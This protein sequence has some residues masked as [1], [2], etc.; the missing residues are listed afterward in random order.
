MVK[1]VW[2]IYY[3]ILTVIQALEIITIASG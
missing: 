2:H 1:M 3:T